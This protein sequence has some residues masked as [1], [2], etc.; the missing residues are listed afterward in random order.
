MDFG[1]IA[2]RSS[3]TLTNR[4]LPWWIENA[5][6]RDRGGIRTMISDE[7]VIT[8][9]DK[10]VWSQARWL[11][12]TSATCN[13]LGATQELIET[14]H[15]T[16]DFLR[17]FGQHEPGRWNFLLS[18]EGCALEG[19]SSIFSDCFAIYGLSEYYRLSKEPW[20]IDL[21]L[22]TFRN[23]IT[24]I[25][26]S[27]FAA[28]RPY[29]M[30]P[31]W[32]AHAVYMILLETAQ[33]LSITLDGFP[34]ADEVADN[35]VARILGNFLQPNNGLIVEY[36]DREFRPFRHSMDALVVPGHAIECMW[37]M[38]HL[39]LRRRGGENLDVIGASLL[40]HLKFGWDLEYGGL[41]LNSNTAG[42][43]RA[44][45]NGEMKIWWPHTEAL[46]ATALLFHATRDERFAKWYERIQ[47]YCKSHFEL[48]NGEWRQR[49]NRD[50]SPSDTLVA[51]PV[52]DPFHLPRALLHQAT[53]KAQF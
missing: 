5:V 52:K 38:A 24:R 35:C 43:R 11:W 36:L 46:Y 40:R 53:L 27:D 4:V 29:R 47:A 14:A 33:E 42:N 7:A 20:A 37:F 9:E 23:V 48:P 28:I 32:R 15:S 51:L 6:D 13:R 50:G 41:V 49:L 21:A 16:A 19:P 1:E 34:E 45:V 30:E 10:F 17:R 22:E 8:G 39:S 44:Y 2:A 18:R 25:E 12:V 26:A 31:G 3:D